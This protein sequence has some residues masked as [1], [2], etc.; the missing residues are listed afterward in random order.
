M[1]K[2]VYSRKALLV[3]VCDLVAQRVRQQSAV[4]DQ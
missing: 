1:Q 4:S 2:G 3:E